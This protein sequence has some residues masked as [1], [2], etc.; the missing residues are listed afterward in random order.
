MLVPTRSASS[1]PRWHTVEKA[2]SAMRSSLNSAIQR[3]HH[4]LLGRS[5]RRSETIPACPDRTGQR[6][7]QEEPAFTWFRMQKPI[8]GRASSHVQ[9][10][11]ERKLS[12]LVKAPTAQQQH[13]QVECE[14][15]IM[16]RAKNLALLEAAR[17]MAEHSMRPSTRAAGPVT[18]AHASPTRARPGVVPMRSTGKS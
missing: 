6:G 10:E 18:T 8:P 13:R 12:R 3:G 2:R 17:D 5:A 1:A 7:Q 4:W 16:C 9:P 15:L 14:A 11:M